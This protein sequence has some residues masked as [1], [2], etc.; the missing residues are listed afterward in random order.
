MSGVPPHSAEVR[1]AGRR[2]RQQSPTDQSPSIP[3]TTARWSSRPPQG[4]KF[5]AKSQQYQV[6]NAQRSSS[7]STPVA[8]HRRLD[9]TQSR[10][11]WETGQEPLNDDTTGFHHSHKESSTSRE[12]PPAS[13]TPT[14][15]SQ[16]PL[17]HNIWLHFRDILPWEQKSTPNSCMWGGDRGWGRGCRRG[18]QVAELKP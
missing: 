1:G 12:Q 10:G 17:C 13:P 16:H 8:E 6:S 2:G 4:Q 9:L 18:R 15:P 7:G 3:S 11:F 14:P 5:Y